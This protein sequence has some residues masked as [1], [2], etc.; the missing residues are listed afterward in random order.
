MIGR[1]QEA[2]K[3]KVQSQGIQLALEKQTKEIGKKQEDVTKDLEQ[4]EPAVKDAE[5][6][7]QGINK[8]QLNEVRNMPNPPALVKLALESICLLLGKIDFSI[9]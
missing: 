7:V 8:Q 5:Q 9:V 3:R 1:Q 4:V 6:A 2:E